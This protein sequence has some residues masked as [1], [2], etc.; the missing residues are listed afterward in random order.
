MNIRATAYVLTALL[1]APVFSVNA[2]GGDQ[3][4]TSL[5]NYTAQNDKNRVRKTLKNAEIRLRD[6][7]SDF[8]CNNLS[9]LRFAMSKDAVEAG[10]F[11]VKKV[12]KKQLTQPESDGATV[13]EWAAANGKGDSPIV[14]AIND[15]IN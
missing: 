6:I 2:V 14:A 13:L 9:L 10:E 4:L 3:V 1:A 15:R 7:Y 5:C 8:Q 11:I 12:S